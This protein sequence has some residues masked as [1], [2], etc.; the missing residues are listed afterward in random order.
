METIIFGQWWRSHHS[1]ALQSC[2]Y[3]RILCYVL[4]RWIRTQH[5][6]LFGKNSWVGSKIH[7]KTELWTLDEERWNSSEIFSQHSLHCISSTKSKSSW[8]KW[9]TQH[10]SKDESSSCLC[11]MTSYG[12]LKTMNRNVLLMPHL[13]RYLQKFQQDVG[14]SSD[15][16]QKR[17]GIILTT[18]D[19]EGNGTESLNWWW[20]N[21]EKADT[22]F[23]EPRVHCLEE[24]SKAKEVDNY[25]YTSV[26][27]VIRLKLF[28]TI[29]SVNQLSIYGAV[30]D[31]CEEYSTCQTRTGRLV[32]AEQSD[33]LFA[34]ADLLIMTPRPSIEIPA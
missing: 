31:L 27:M 17:S 14:H 28:R 16:D 23:S 1:P 13:C 32:V 18:E 21:S 4:D 33:P 25:R 8:T 11:S 22:Q 6:I 5:Q 12:E 3:F 2:M 9:A 10:N 30:S 19:H 29:I 26:P 7:H 34:P 20:S 24:F 15:L